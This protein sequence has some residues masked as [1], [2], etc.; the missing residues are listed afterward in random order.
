SMTKTTEPV[1][2]KQRRSK[3]GIQEDADHKEPLQ[4]NGTQGKAVTSGE[5]AVATGPAVVNA[6]AC[7][8]DVMV[9]VAQV[10]SVHERSSFDFFLVIDPLFLLPCVRSPAPSNLICCAFV[11][12]AFGGAFS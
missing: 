11:F 7:L 3:Q 10:R 9:V 6:M 1:E 12:L 2:H 8:C 5:P 4:C